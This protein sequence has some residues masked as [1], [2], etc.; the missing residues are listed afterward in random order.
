[1]HKNT[2]TPHCGVGARTDRPWPRRHAASR[3]V[4]AA[5]RETRASGGTV[6]AAQEEMGTAVA[7]EG[8]R[9]T[10]HR[11]RRILVCLDRSTLSEVCV[12][13]ALSM[14]KAFGSAIT[15]AHVMQPHHDTGGPRTSDA[16]G[17]EISRQEARAYLERLQKEVAQVFGQPVDVTLEQG[18]PADRLVD[19]AREV[20]ADLIMLGSRGAGGAAAHA[21]GSTVLQVLAATRSSLFIARPGSNGPAEA[22]PKRILVALD[23]FASKRERPA[24]RRT[25]GGRSRRRDAPCPRRPRAAPDRIA[26]R[27]PRTLRSRAPWPGASSPGPDDTWSGSSGNWHARWTLVRM[28][29]VQHAQRT[30][31]HSRGIGAGEDRF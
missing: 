5:G 8:S 28:V 18:R 10:P 19:V 15:L 6:I 23:G 29:V 1:M 7:T 30:S 12:P 17:W 2:R 31:V 16:L 3:F 24:R 26:T 4:S 22:T 21:L 11:G 14:A 13:H 27:Q 9:G 20:S 25:S